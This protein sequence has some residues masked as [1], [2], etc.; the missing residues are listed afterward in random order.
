MFVTVLFCNFCQFHWQLSFE[1]LIVLLI[2]ENLKH[3]KVNE[4]SELK[5]PENLN[6]ISHR[7]K[8]MVV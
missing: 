4:K 6:K 2:E 8:E 7:V 1:K 5:N 3:L